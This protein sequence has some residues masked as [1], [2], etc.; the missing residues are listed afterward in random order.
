MFPFEL[1][2]IFS[3]GMNPLIPSAMGWIGP[4]PFFYKAGFGIK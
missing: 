1:I 3:K 2:D 4:L